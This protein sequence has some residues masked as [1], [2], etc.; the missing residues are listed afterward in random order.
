VSQC[1]CPSVLVPVIFSTGSRCTRPPSAPHV[2]WISPDRVPEAFAKKLSRYP[3]VPAALVGRLAVDFSIGTSVLARHCCWLE[4]GVAEDGRR[5]RGVWKVANLPGSLRRVRGR[6]VFARTG[7]LVTAATRARL[8]H[9]VRIFAGARTAETR[10]GVSVPRLS[11]RC[12]SVFLRCRVRRAGDGNNCRQC[13]GSQHADFRS[14]A[15]SSHKD[16]HHRKRKCLRCCRPTLRT[17]FRE[18]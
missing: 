5:T 4:V 3:E 10:P 11:G 16:R 2:E 7:S 1:S 17:R 13:N 15:N 8:P 18:S 6:F 9:T 14:H 12:A